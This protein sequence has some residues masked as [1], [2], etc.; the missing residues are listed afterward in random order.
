MN[1]YIMNASGQAMYERGNYAMAA[2]EFEKALASVPHNPDYASNLAKTRAR[3]GDV[4]SA[5]KL[6]RSNLTKSP[7]HQPTYHGLAELLVSQ[8]RGE[9]ATSLLSTWSATQPH[10]AEAHLEMAWLQKQLGHSD[11]AAQSAQRA[12]QLNPGHPKALAWMGDHYHQ[13][14]QPNQALGMYQ[15]SLQ[16]QWNQPNVHSRLA[17]ASATASPTHPVNATALAQGAPPPGYRGRVAA[18]PPM[19][20]MMAQA[21][22]SHPHAR[23]GRMQAA[24]PMPF[25]PGFDGPMSVGFPKPVMQTAAHSTQHPTP[26]PGFRQAAEPMAVNPTTVVSHETLMKPQAANGVPELQAF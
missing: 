9:E 7:S 11:A 3:M 4:A 14:G 21:I 25:G 8:G 22:P 19:P 1:G 5:E 23:Y 24:S 18:R 12:L 20:P 2:G 26:D 6:Y 17:A 15:Q 16:S 13:T 10:E